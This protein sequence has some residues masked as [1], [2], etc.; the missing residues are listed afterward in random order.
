MPAAASVADRYEAVVAGD[1]DANG[2]GDLVL[3]DRGNGFAVL[4]W[5]GRKA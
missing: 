5:A 2:S 1:F 3:Y 4:W